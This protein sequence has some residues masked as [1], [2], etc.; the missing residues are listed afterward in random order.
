MPTMRLARRTVLPVRHPLLFGF[1]FSPLLRRIRHLPG[2]REVGPALLPGGRRVQLQFL[3]PGGVRHVPAVRA[4][5][6]CLLPARRHMLRVAR[7]RRGGICRR[8]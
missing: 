2:M 5:G 8:A 3:L 1:H 4:R 7:L 6:V